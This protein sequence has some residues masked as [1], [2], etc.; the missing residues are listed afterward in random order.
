[1]FKYIYKIGQYL[2]NPSISKHF[3]F[4]KKT[5]KWTINQLEEYQLEKLKEIIK[6]AYNHSVFYREFYD[7]N[8]V[9]IQEIKTLSDITKLPVFTKKHL[10]ENTKNIQTDLQFKKLYKANTS[11]SSGTSLAF[12]RE[13][14]ADSFN[15]ASIL[16][17]YSWYNVKYW[18]RNGYFW[19]Y[20]YSFMQKI[21]T[22]LL[23]FLQNRFRIFDY[24][25]KE[26]SSFIKKLSKAEY[27]H[28]YSSMIYRTAKIINERGVVFTNKLKMVK[29]TSEKIFEKYQTE[30]QKAFNLKM[31][32][33]YGAT[34]S[35][36][37]A[38]E[39]PKGNMH[40]NMEGV[41]VEEVDKEIIITNLQMQSFPIIRYKLGDYVTLAK[42]EK[43]CSCGMEHYIIEE[44]TGRIGEDIIG[45]KSIYPSL[46]IYYIFKNLHNQHNLKLT[47]QVVQ[48]KEGYLLF[49][50]EEEL[51]ESDRIVLLNE[52]KKYFDSDIECIIDDK[53]NLQSS[54]KKMKSFISAIK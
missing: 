26:F 37:I 39:C 14:S 5:E 33:E 24:S 4:L 11:G 6:L 25:D 9:D 10:L 34:E 42:K 1:M 21:K 52:I 3:Y 32:S 18:D 43:K 16:R 46:V 38:F 50:V 35:G 49:K 20:S 45:K 27:I 40:I 12:Y 30:V 36:I 15:R 22:K 41:L 19:G 53:Q 44:I 23:D 7:K 31:V 51:E 54:D 8:G 2:R 13:E 29:G 28:G 47:Y 48:E 17:G